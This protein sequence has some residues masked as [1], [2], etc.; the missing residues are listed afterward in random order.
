MRQ[1]QWFRNGD[2][3]DDN[4]T[5][6]HDESGHSFL[7]EGKVVRYYRHPNLCGVTHCPKCERTLDAHGWIDDNG[8]SQVVCPGDYIYTT[9]G[10]SY[11]VLPP[12]MVNTLTEEQIKVMLSAWDTVPDTA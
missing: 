9:F 2:H 3:P 11:V 8:R 5:I 6:I 12:Q 1:V 10:G 4:S 7:T